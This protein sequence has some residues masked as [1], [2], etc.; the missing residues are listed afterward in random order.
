MRRENHRAWTAVI[1]D[2]SSDV[3][4]YVDEPLRAIFAM[5]SGLY[6]F[7]TEVAESGAGKVLVRHREQAAREH[8]GF[9]SEGEQT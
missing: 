4:P 6:S 7:V 2:A 5:P 1:I 9:E 8:Y 3:Q